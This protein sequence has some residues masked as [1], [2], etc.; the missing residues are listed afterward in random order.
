LF[1]AA[2]AAALIWLAAFAATRSGA[3]AWF[4]WAAT[5]SSLTFLIQ[6]VTVFPDGVGMAA[7]A[8]G[9]W[10]VCRL[11]ASERATAILPL[12]AVSIA[13]AALPWLHSRFVVLAVG[14]GVTIVW[15]MTRDARGSLAPRLAAFLAAP[16]ISAA[17][18]FAFFK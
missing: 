16:V 11:N 14:L 1:L 8:A 6:S 9:V 3:A 5:V 4:A 2:I 12:V 13:L 7:V 17:A 18:W 10:L 15:Q